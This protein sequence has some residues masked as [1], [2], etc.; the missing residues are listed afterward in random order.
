MN[1]LLTVDCVSNK[2]TISSFVAHGCQLKY[3][4]THFLAVFLKTI[5]WLESLIWLLC[6][7][8]TSIITVEVLHVTFKQFATKIMYTVRYYNW[9]LT[10][11]ACQWYVGLHSHTYGQ[12]HIYQSMVNLT[13]DMCLH[14]STVWTKNIAINFMLVIPTSLLCFLFVYS[15][16]S[17]PCKIGI[18]VFNC[19]EILLVACTGPLHISLW[20]PLA[21]IILLLFLLCHSSF[22]VSLHNSLMQQLLFTGMQISLWSMELF[23]S[24]HIVRYQLINCNELQSHLFLDAVPDANSSCV[25]FFSQRFFSFSLRA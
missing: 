18:S 6:W 7:V 24:L 14:T 1:K 12:G 4:L 25:I 9:L 13:R 8:S 10:S 2:L 5:N 3:K 17:S 16:T 21:K 19:A 23:I 20:E 15:Y 22:W 11:I